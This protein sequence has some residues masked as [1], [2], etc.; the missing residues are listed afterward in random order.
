M[1]VTRN[2]IANTIGT[3][4]FIAATA[5][6][7]VFSFRIAG[8]EQFGLIGF[9]LTLHGI[10]AVL[11]VGLG[12]GIVREVAQARAGS[13]R[14]GIG[15][16][17]YTFQGIYAGLTGVTTTILLAGSWLL[18]GLINA[19][20]IG[21]DEIHLALILT[22]F[23]IGAQ[24]LRSV[25]TIFLEGMEQQVMANILQSGGAVVRAAVA[26]AAM[27]VFTPSAV[28]F[29][30]ASLT[31][32]VLEVLVNGL[33]A[34]RA[35]PRG[36]EKAHFS[37]P[38]IRELAHF[39]ATSSTAGMLGAL[40][41]NADKLMVSTLLPL[42]VTGRYLFISQICLIVVKLVVPNV[43]AVLPRL[44]AS[45]HRGDLDDTRKVYF[46]AGAT[47]SSLVAVF[48]FGATFFGADALV[49][50]TGSADVA[51]DYA[52]LFALLAWAYGLN[53]LCYLPNA[54]LLAEGHPETSFWSNA[55]ATAC[56]LPSLYMLTPD[57]GAVAPAFLWLVTNAMI[58]V[59][60]V[61][62]AH[63]YGLSRQRGPWLRTSLI[64][65]F[66]V[67]GMMLYAARIM[68]GDSASPV[69]VSAVVVFMSGMA[70]AIAAF[71]SPELRLAVFGLLR[72]IAGS[73]SPVDQ[74]A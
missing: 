47:A 41:Q 20:S 15:T 8:P 63:F 26:I 14:A 52:R 61:E 66:A 27:L 62:R 18:A 24:R 70:L 29:L 34:W 33:V 43:T 73:R 5:A 71:V 19:R 13:G 25:F 65:Q 6:T 68:L 42:D 7:S 21:A 45:V 51:N 55:I 64:P 3:V 22:A 32:C 30:A 58:F 72:K 59:V 48:V 31:M 23:T 56:Y 67:G 54:L 38:L 69:I 74:A 46:A 50:L 2:V 49:I 1:A 10:V 60:F 16:I 11:D 12:P 28:V 44:S 40:L 9:Y 37:L 57:Y 17:L 39:L 36:D 53:S 35:V 4:A